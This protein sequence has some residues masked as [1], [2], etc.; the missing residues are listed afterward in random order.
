MRSPA[1]S[2]STGG[3]NDNLLYAYEY[4]RADASPSCSTN[5]GAIEDNVG[6]HGADIAANDDS[7][8]GTHQYW[9][10]ANF[11][12]DYSQDAITYCLTSSPVYANAEMFINDAMYDNTAKKAVGAAAQL[13][14][15][16]SVTNV[17][18]GNQPGGKSNQADI[19]VS[20]LSPYIP[21]NDQ[22]IPRASFWAYVTVYANYTKSGQNDHAASTQ[23]DSSADGFVITLTSMEVYSTAS[24]TLENEQ[25]N[26]FENWTSGW[27][28]GNVKV[29]IGFD[30]GTYSNGQS[31]SLYLG[32][33]YTLTTTGMPSGWI[34]HQWST[35]GGTLTSQTADP[36]SITITGSGGVAA[37]INTTATLS[38]VGYVYSPETNSAVS[39]VGA[40]YV[41]QQLT[42]NSGS[43]S[44]WVGI[45]GIN[46]LS[47]LWQAGIY[48]TTTG[49]QAFYETYGPTG[50][51]NSCLPVYGTMPVS[52]GD[53]VISN[54]W[55]NGT[56]TISFRIHDVTN[57]NTWSGTPS[58]S[59]V[60]T[61]TGDWIMEATGPEQNANFTMLDVAG[62]AA[63]LVGGYLIP[64]D[65]FLANGIL[66]PYYISLLGTYNGYAT[67]AAG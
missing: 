47:N 7:G 37:I 24:G 19:Q 27:Q 59:Y 34:L 26:T 52:I 20:Y 5:T 57:G 28:D 44:T 2:F 3:S 23:D 9:V 51:V 8:N 39:S 18:N 53:T 54:V 29:C 21:Y 55:F 36:T 41:V 50:C 32:A 22:L 61:R 45:G 66:H 49:A 62:S 56:G 67:F 30:C 31:A 43:S 42:Q 33:T 12:M 16:S 38:W 63:P 58:T 10:I 65:S 14:E 46:S 6:T 48:V 11:T 4:T 25:I 64:L 13:N 15:N 40:K 17:C 1:N 60:P 35:N